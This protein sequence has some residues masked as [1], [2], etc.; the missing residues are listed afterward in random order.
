MLRKF[1]SATKLV[2]EVRFHVA[3]LGFHSLST[4]FLFMDVGGGGKSHRALRRGNGFILDGAGLSFR[5]L[6]AT[7]IVIKG[8]SPICFF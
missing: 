6:L 3:V 1:P 8:L 7:T 4:S 5:E 2:I